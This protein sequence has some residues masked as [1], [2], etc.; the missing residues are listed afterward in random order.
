MP[1][2]D[3]VLVVCESIAEWYKFRYRGKHINVI[4]NAPSARSS[5]PAL[6]RDLRAEI[7]AS[8]DDVLFLYLG[9]LEYGRGIPLLLECFR[10]QPAHRKL[11]FIGY[12]SLVN[13][14]KEAARTCGNISYHPAVPS[15][16][17]VAVASSADVGICLLDS[18]ALSYRYALP[19]KLFEYCAAGLPTIVN[20]DYPEMVRF[21][22]TTSSGWLVPPSKEALGDILATIDAAAVS[23]KRQEM[24]M[25]GPAPTWEQEAPKLIATYARHIQCDAE[26]VFRAN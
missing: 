17:V 13:N 26:S 2:V 3:D 10:G 18:E 9:G 6:D 8:A 12:G 23:A 14:V 19:N 1:F 5:T 25:H 11:L 21:V 4:Y 24:R 20:A 22:S 7:G 15:D 16:Q